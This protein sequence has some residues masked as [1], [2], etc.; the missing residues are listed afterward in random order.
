MTRD[1]AQ[2]SKSKKP[3]AK[4]ATA[5]R[6]IALIVPHAIADAGVTFE[7]AME[8]LDQDL[9]V[10]KL[11]QAQPKGPGKRGTKSPA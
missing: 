4:A 3:E 5:P 9:H 8:V 7:T 10:H 11:W 6:Q 1:T 2:D